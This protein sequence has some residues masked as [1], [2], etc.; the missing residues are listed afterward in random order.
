MCDVR[1]WNFCIT[2]PT[3]QLELWCVWIDEIYKTYL[4]CD[5]NIIYHLHVLTESEVITGKFQ[6]EAE[7]E[8]KQGRHIKV[9]V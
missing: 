2:R 4:I 5:L 9:K 8:R 3:G 1:T 6:T 7:T